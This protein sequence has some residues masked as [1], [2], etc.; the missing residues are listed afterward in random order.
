MQVL[1]NGHNKLANI[2]IDFKD[3]IVHLDIFPG[4]YSIS[5]F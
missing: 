2:L 3:F 1:T 5:P 4:F